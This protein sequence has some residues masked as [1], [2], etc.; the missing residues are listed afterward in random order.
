MTVE[1]NRV[2]ERAYQLWEEAGRTG[3]PEDHW[4]RAERDL[5]EELRNAV[6]IAGKEGQPGWVP[7]L[8][9]RGRLRTGRPFERSALAGRSKGKRQLAAKLQVLEHFQPADV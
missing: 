5:E 6:P 2:R 3:V 8:D 9:G 7:F 1:H 4:L